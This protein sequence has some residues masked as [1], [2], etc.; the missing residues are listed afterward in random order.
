MAHEKLNSYLLET[1]NPNNFESELPARY[2][3]HLQIINAICGGHPREV[4]LQ[5][6]RSSIFKVLTLLR[7]RERSKRLRSLSFLMI[8]D[9]EGVDM[10]YDDAVSIT[11]DITNCTIQRL[12]ISINSSSDINFYDAFKKI[13]NFEEDLK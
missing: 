13:E 10:P 4:S 2:E 8:K 3:K 11:V 9:L 5:Q 6:L 1:I 7:H 12:L